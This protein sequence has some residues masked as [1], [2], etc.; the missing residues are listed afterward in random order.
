MNSAAP[1][2]E[3]VLAAGETAMS[4]FVKA[5]DATRARF[6]AAFEGTDLWADEKAFRREF[7]DVLPRFEAARMASAERDPI[8]AQLAGSVAPFVHWHDAQ[9]PRALS[10]ALQEPTAPLPLTVHSFDRAPG[11][12]P[13]FVYRVSAGLQT[14]S[15]RLVKF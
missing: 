13:S 6:P 1:G 15:V 7:V 10:E 14:A 3:V 9:G 5:L 12:S 4:L 8:A 11:W 2:G